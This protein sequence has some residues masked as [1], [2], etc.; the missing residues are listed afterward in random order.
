[1]ATFVFQNS[2]GKAHGNKHSDRLLI[3]IMALNAAA[4]SPS[5][6]KCLI[7]LLNRNITPAS[8]AILEFFRKSLA[9]TR[10]HH[11]VNVT[12]R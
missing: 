10:F 1:M 12:T 11:S 9:I 3:I 4:L 5:N 6:N 7:S 2:V 8:S